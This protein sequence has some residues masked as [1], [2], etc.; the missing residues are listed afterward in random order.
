MFHAFGNAT[1]VPPASWR[2]EPA[3][4]GTF[5]IL[6]SCLI[7]LGLCLWTALHLNIPR[8]NEGAWV[9]PM[10]K[11]SW[12]LLG[13]LAPEMIAYTAWYQRQAALNLTAVAKRRL[14]QPLEGSIIQKL[15]AF[16]RRSDPPDKSE[17]EDNQT[18]TPTVKRHYQWTTV[19]S[20]YTNMGGFVFDTTEVDAK[21]LPNSRER[22]TLTPRGLLYILEHEPDLIPDISEKQIWD[23]SKAG[24]L[25]KTLICLQ[26]IWFCVQCIVRFAQGL[27]ISL[28]ELNVFCHAICA[29]LMYILWWDKPMDIEEPTALR[30]KVVREMCALMCMRSSDGHSSGCT[31]LPHGVRYGSASDR[32]I[33][34]AYVSN[35]EK[36]PTSILKMLLLAVSFPVLLCLGIVL[37]VL[38][39]FYGLFR[40]CKGVVQLFGGKHI[41]K[42]DLL[43]HR[44]TLECRLKWTAPRSVDGQLEGAD[45]DESFP[46]DLTHSSAD[47]SEFEGRTISPPSSTP[48]GIVDHGVYVTGN[49]ATQSPQAPP[50]S[51]STSH[52]DGISLALGKWSQGAFFPWQPTP[53][54]TPTSINLSAT[55][56]ARWRLCASAL[57]RYC[58]ST[59][60]LQEDGTDSHQDFPAHQSVCDRSPDWPLSDYLSCAGDGRK[61]VT[62][63]LVGFSIAGLAYGGLHL[64]AWDAPF[65]SQLEHNLWRISGI[66]LACSGMVFTIGFL[67][68]KWMIRSG[69][70]K[71]R[72]KLRTQPGRLNLVGHFISVIVIVAPVYVVCGVYIGA[73]GIFGRGIFHPAGAL[74]GHS[75]SVAKMV[76]VFPAYLVGLLT[77]QMSF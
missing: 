58:P 5:N 40:I 35:D 24:N 31:E 37:Y 69:L 32:N 75:V 42:P 29:L 59:Q 9:T 41:E 7:T 19:H 25:A 68:R 46:V 44:R 53:D 63:I 17:M 8:H 15:A 20:F 57:Q 39:P 13:L 6:S 1:Q 4:R 62:A 73:R 11:A 66:I 51:I 14:G 70:T 30:G 23:K 74:A 67:L 34:E 55:D 26:A 16:F 28:L 12:L 61:P 76:A 52:I 72:K 77:S 65:S 48:A 22:L 18:A 21:F 36:R 3:T 2:D 56:V 54:H 38:L 64:L 43:G 47:A 45:N 10:R 50:Q 27:A 49:K 71:F 60:R 33:A